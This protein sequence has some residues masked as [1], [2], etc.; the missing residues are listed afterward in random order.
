MIKKTLFGLLALIVALVLA[1]AINTLRKGSRQLNVP[2][3]AVLPVDQA[4]AASRL[5]EAVRLST[6]SA[7]DD[8]KLRELESVRVGTEAACARR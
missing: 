8:A 1:V 2:P 3:L 6:I 4:G 5:G 7:R